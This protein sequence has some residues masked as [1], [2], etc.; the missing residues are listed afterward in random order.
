MTGPDDPNP[1]PKYPKLSGNRKE[2]FLKDWKK[3]LDENISKEGR[4]LIDY[5]FYT[6]ISREE[7]E[8]EQ[9]QLLADGIQPT[10]TTYEDYLRNLH[11]SACKW[12]PKK[13]SKP[14]TLD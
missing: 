1:A 9:K 10:D 5:S 2:Q 7:W 13:L 3:E 4:E 11:A 12:G 6:P 14:A 8:Q